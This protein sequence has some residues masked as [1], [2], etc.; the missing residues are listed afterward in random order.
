MTILTKLSKKDFENILNNYNIGNHIS[1]KNIFTGTNTVYAIKTTKGKFLVKIYENASLDFIKDQIRLMEFLKKTKVSTPKIVNTKKKK[2]LL[3]YNKKR[4]AIQEFAK[5]KEIENVKEKLAKNLG[6]EFGILSKTLLKYKNSGKDDWGEDHEFKLI[7]WK[8]DNVNN[9]DVKKESKVLCNQLKTLNKK[10]L[11]K[12]VVHG[13]LCEGNFLVNKN[14]LTAIIDWDDFHRDYL[15][16]EVAVPIGHLLVN[17]KTVKRK[18]IKLFL[19]EYQKQIKLN[20]EE[21]KALYYF[22][23]QRLLAASS[24]C[25]NQVGKHKGKKSTFLRWAG[26]LINK[27]KTFSKISLEDF[28]ELAG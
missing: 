20:S 10:K 28:L 13:D 1:H 27:Y 9:F 2:G 26:I 7:K 14:Q 12:S 21:K 3:V 19:T 23:K 4:L 5:G 17:K 15:I 18:E 22:T 25:V 24:W 6:K 8:L 16:S 11:R